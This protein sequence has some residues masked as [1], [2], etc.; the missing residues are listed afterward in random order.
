MSIDMSNDF[1]KDEFE[2]ALELDLVPRQPILPPH[3]L[4]VQVY[5]QDFRGLAYRDH[6]GTWRD[7]YKNEPL[8]GAVQLVRFDC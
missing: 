3:A 1:S 4:P 7:Y 2:L 6:E 8:R 5:T